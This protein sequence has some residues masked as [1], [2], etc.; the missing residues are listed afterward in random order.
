M[1]P[2]EMLVIMPS[3]D[4]SEIARQH[5]GSLPRSLRVLLRSMGALNAGGSELM[6]YL[7]FQS[8]F[9]R[10]LIDLGYQDAMAQNNRL[11][12]FMHG[13]MVATTGMTAVMRRLDLKHGMAGA[14]AADNAAAHEQRKQ[15]QN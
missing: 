5:V 14:D 12:D 9:T 10:D 1:K 6:S 2:I 11:V 4:I 7:M 15:T 3:R 8:S 13:D